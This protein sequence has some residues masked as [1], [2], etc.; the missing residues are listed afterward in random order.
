MKRILAMLLVLSVVFCFVACKHNV[1]PDTTN[2]QSGATEGTAPTAG[3]QNQGVERKNVYI[4]SGITAN[5]ADGTK[6]Y[7]YIWETLD[8]RI[9]NTLTASVGGKELKLSFN[10][11]E[12]DRAGTVTGLP[13]GVVVDFVWDELGRVISMT[14]TSTGG[15]YA[16]AYTYDGEGRCV[17]KSVS[18]NGQKASDVAYVYEGDKLTRE[19]VTLPDGSVSSEKTNLY[20]EHGDLTQEVT[21]Y[22]GAETVVVKYS[23]TYNDAGQVLSKSV[24]GPDEQETE[25][26]AY[27]YDS[28]GRVLTETAFAGDAR[29]AHT[30]YSYNDRGELVKELQYLTGDEAAVT[31][32]YTYTEVRMSD[33]EYALYQMVQ[34]FSRDWF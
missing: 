10:Y 32:E 25:K 11:R 34:S 12:S 3:N 31:V 23:Y 21:K 7:E 27:T 9:M 6:P 8:R 13:S 26:Y 28:E 19:T 14:E 17:G 16:V 29:T 33:E 15:T 24:L 30:A 18:R 1:E 2:P 22:A 5:N 20:N 4:L